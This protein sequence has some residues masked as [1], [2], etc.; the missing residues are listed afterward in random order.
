MRGLRYEIRMA[1]HS[2]G[3]VRYETFDAKHSARNIRCGTFDTKHLIRNIRYETSMGYETFDTKHLRGKY[4]RAGQR[5]F[6]L[7]V[8]TFNAQK[9]RRPRLWSD[10]CPV[11]SNPKKFTQ[12]R[13]SL[14]CV[15]RGGERRKLDDAIRL[16]YSARREKLHGYP[17]RETEP[18]NSVK[19]DETKRARSHGT[20][21]RIP[22]ERKSELLW[23]IRRGDRPRGWQGQ[24]PPSS[25]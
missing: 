14:S 25:R 11:A 22:R 8:R 7:F 10:L 21:Q 16:R 6:P 24:A 23:K 1:G 20:D 12:H 2:I 19:T 13:W 17:Q 15:K 4:A 9:C 5:H 3:N 18:Q